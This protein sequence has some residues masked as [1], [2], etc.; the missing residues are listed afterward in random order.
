MA[1]IQQICRIGF[2]KLSEIESK[3]MV[4]SENEQYSA[5]Y[6]NYNPKNVSEYFLLFG[7]RAHSCPHLSQKV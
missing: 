6:E 1:P 7:I 2:G 5:I 3:Q 4:D